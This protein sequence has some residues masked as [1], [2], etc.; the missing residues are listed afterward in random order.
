MSRGIS[1]EAIVAIKR[2]ANEDMVTYQR[3]KLA[4][5]DTMLKAKGGTR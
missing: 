1:D 2:L 4:A 5:R 3:I